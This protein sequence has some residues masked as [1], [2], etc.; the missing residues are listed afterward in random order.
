MPRQIFAPRSSSRED[1]AFGNR[2]DLRV[3]DAVRLDLTYGENWS[4]IRFLLII[5]KTVKI[6]VLA[7]GAY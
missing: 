6:V 7:D 3:E 5:A 2:S 1:P 4:L